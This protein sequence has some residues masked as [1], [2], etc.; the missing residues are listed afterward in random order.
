MQRWNMRAFES[1]RAHFNESSLRYLFFER[2]LGGHAVGLDR[3]TPL[4][5]ANDLD[6]EIATILRK[7]GNFSF[8][9]TSYRLLLSSKGRG[10]VPRELNI[11]TVRDRLVFAAL[12]QVLDDV[13]GIACRTCQPQ[14]VVERVK[15]CVETG[16]YSQCLKIDIRGFYSSIPHDKL[17]RTIRKRIRKKEVLRL[18]EAAIKTPSSTFGEKAL[19]QRYEGVPEGLSISNRLAN[20]FVENLDAVFAKDPSI[21]YFRYVDDILIFC[22]DDGAKVVQSKLQG[23]IDKLGL[24][25]NEEKTRLINLTIDSLDYLGYVFEPSGSLT[26]RSLTVKRLEKTIDEK[27]RKMRGLD[28][29]ASLLHHV[30]NRITGCRITEDGVNFERYGWLHYYSRIDDIGLLCRLDLFINKLLVRYNL[31]IQQDI[32]CFK[33]AFYEIKY[34]ADRTKYIPTY[35]MNASREV[36][37]RDLKQLFPSERW[38]GLDDATVNLLY[39]RKIRSMANQLEKDL[40][41][42]S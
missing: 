37:L 20:I 42:I 17:M 9:F 18:I 10:R 41:L 21:T 33:K 40:G 29:L 34:K 25:I 3:I 1:Y 35:D 5:F 30:N 7:V 6:R 31:P 23:T 39:S 19:G 4:R 22:S 2:V 8:Q 28:D 26:V 27:L 24:T 14:L 32:K 11:P 38:D 12:S 16:R 13:Y 15:E 36:K